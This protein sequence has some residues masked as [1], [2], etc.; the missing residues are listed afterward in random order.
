MA[1][2]RD[3]M[4]AKYRRRWRNWS[5]SVAAVPNFRSYPVAVPQIQ[6]E[7]L[8][9]AE[10]G[11]RIRVGGSGQSFS[12]LSWTDEN[13]LS[14]DYFT[15]IE[16]VDIQQRRVWIRSGTRL[17]QLATELSDRGLALQIFSS[18]GA[19]TLA[20]AI[21]TGMHGSGIGFGNLSSQVTALRMVCADGRHRTISA[22]SNPEML[23]AARLSLGA[24]G[25]IT[26]VELQ[27]VEAARLHLRTLKGTLGETLDR[28]N[29]LKRTHRHFD[30]KWFP[31]TDTVQLNFMDPTGAG[32]SYP[33]VFE[34]A[35]Q[36]VMDNSALWMLSEMSR[37]IPRSSSTASRLAAYAATDSE[38]VGELPR[39]REG[40][41]LI[42]YDEIE[43]S[44]PV[45]RLPAVIRQIDQLMRALHFRVHMPLEVRFARRDD[46]W[47]SPNHQ[48]DSAFI[49]ARQYRGMPHED[50]FAALTDIFDRN[51]GR[52]SWSSLHDKTA[53][54][55]GQL[56]PR[57]TDFQRLRR[58]LDPR[59]VFL[60]PHLKAIF[61]VEQ[62]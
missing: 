59:G 5:G 16:S 46:L 11:E 17:R 24:L 31:Y 53:Y 14:L 22:D 10:E 52:P 1:R 25:V 19:Q 27:C 7:V 44:I 36:Q 35:R 21:S 48:R 13:L 28:I 29:P 30:F 45:Q 47:L 4:I 32:E 49:A 37:R 51:E 62:S 50:Y 6:A 43:F 61:G 40:R 12:P 55:L 38:S 60:N 58:E 39:H 26:H 3:S 56:Y 2:Y 23:D 57:F 18:S 15:G 8:R 33:G 34:R 20:G 54:E 9:A 42:R 41:R